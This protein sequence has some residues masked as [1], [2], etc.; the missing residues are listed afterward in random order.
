RLLLGLEPGPPELT[1]EEDAAYDTAIERAIRAARR[2]ARHVQGQRTEARKL[3]RI[4][5]QGGLEAVEKL[6]RKTGDL[7][8]FEALLARSWSL[9]H[10]NPR[11]MA[12][13]AWLAVKAAEQLD[14]VRYGTE[15]V[16]DF[17]CRA[18]DEL[19]TASRALT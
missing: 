3:E 18:H 17:Q 2:L 13:F 6:P 16:C 19:G 5:A 15:R 10:E 4:L 8:L 7:A 1:P 9:R 11:L 12:Q 14:A